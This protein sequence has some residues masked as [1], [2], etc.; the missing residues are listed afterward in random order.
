MTVICRSVMGYKSGEFRPD[1]SILRA[2]GPPPEVRWGG[3]GG[4]GGSITPSED[5]GQK[6]L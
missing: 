3:V 5:M 6:V 4:F 1:S 2:P